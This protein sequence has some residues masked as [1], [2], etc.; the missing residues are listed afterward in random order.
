M[1]IS[2]FY[3][4]FRYALAAWE[5]TWQQWR[6]HWIQSSGTLVLLLLGTALWATFGSPPWDTLGEELQ[7]ILWVA[8][9][10]AVIFVLTFLRNWLVQPFRE[11]VDRLGGCVQQL[12]TELTSAS[13]PQLADEAWEDLDPLNLFQASCLEVGLKPTWPLPHQKAEVALIQ[14]SRA[15]VEGRLVCDY[16]D[17]AKLF[18]LRSAPSPRASVRRADLA[19]YYDQSGL[20][21]P[22]F[23]LEVALPTTDRGLEKE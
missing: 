15:V 6:E 9:G 16:L 14:L 13:H 4:P 20:E 8:I 18:G 3:G 2:R 22:S 5:H 7:V 11:H 17:L 10:G 1:M 21:R 19:A 12:S 23:L